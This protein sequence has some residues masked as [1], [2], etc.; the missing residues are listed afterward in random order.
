M[1]LS[2]N[3]RKRLVLYGSGALVALL[4]AVLPAL[5]RRMVGHVSIR[6]LDVKVAQAHE[7]S[8]MLVDYLRIDTTNPP[9]LVRPAVEFLARAFACEGI[10]Y[11]VVGGDPARPILVARLRGRSPEGAL[12]LLNHTDVV[13]PGDLGKW[14]RPPFAGEMGK[15]QDWFYLYG[16]GTLDMK[17]VAVAQFFALAELKRAGLVPLRDVVFLAEPEEETFHPEL[18]TGWVLDHR[19]DLLRG[20]TDVLNEGGVNEVVTS[21]IRRFGIEVLQKASVGLNVDAK[22]RESL[23]SL[24]TFLKER[25]KEFPLRM[26]EPVR[27]FLRFIGPSRGD[28]WGRMM[29]DPDRVLSSKIFDLVAPDVYRWLLRDVLYVGDVE[30]RAEGGFTMQVVLIVLPGSPVT[31]ARRKLEGWVNERGLTSRLAFQTPDSVAT[32]EEGRVWEVLHRV[33]ALD[34]ERA[35]V[36]AYVIP[37]SYTSSAYLRS[38][39]YRAYGL[40]PFNVNLWDAAKVHRENERINIVTFV[41]GVDRMKRIVLEFATSP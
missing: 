37:I 16:R 15:G 30:P 10:P 35:E 23:K 22:D 4:V 26:V 38:R 34:P 39:G 17:S 40:S 14:A 6:A 27:E 28:V 24:G 41:E 9:G 33:L 2:R 25:D 29:Y 20:V 8:R 13:P 1:G 3:A 7:A 19:S 12:L 36:G 11:E 31:E 32:P 21:D 5:V 18:G